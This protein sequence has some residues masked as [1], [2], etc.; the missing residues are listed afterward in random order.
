[1]GWNG[2][3]EASL[4]CSGSL[5]LALWLL[6][7]NINIFGC[8]GSWMLS[9]NPHLVIISI[10]HLVFEIE[11][12]EEETLI[13]NHLEICKNVLTITVRT[14]CYL[15]KL[16]E[17]IYYMFRKLARFDQCFSCWCSLTLPKLISSLVLDRL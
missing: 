17:I 15:P 4:C 1:M 16:Y 13:Q 5:C 14:N 11:R 6:M 10:H 8:V 3:I 9:L 7:G 12:N 2:K